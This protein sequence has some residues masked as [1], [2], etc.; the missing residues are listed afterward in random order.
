MEIELERTFLAKRLPEGFEKSNSTEIID[1]YIPASAEHPVLRIRKRG[2]SFEMTK[3][4]PLAGTDSSEQHEQTIFLSETEYQELSRI[5][6][7]RF[8]KIRHYYN[9]ENRTAE[10]D[11]YK[12]DLEG[13]V[14]VDF[15]FD[16]SEKKN[17]FQM[18]DFCLADVTQEKAFA[19]GI[20]AGKAYSDIEPFLAKYGYHKIVYP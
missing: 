16:S 3:K 6:G 13:L 5:K 20:L 12:D 2:D 4:M 19:G 11:V 7:K 8:R 1:I 15:E 14:A 10:I 9:F 18:P 17:S